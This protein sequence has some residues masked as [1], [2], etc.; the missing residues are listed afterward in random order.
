MTTLTIPKTLKEKGLLIPDCASSLYQSYRFINAE[1]EITNFI[2]E[3]NLWGF[4]L[5]APW[6]IKRVFGDDIVL[7]L[8]LHR[9]PTEDFEC[10][11]VT[12]RTSLPPES[13]VNLLAR[14]DEEWWL[15]VDD[16]IRNVLEIMVW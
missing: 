2:E 16:G 14:L 6:Q 9:D 11:F 7:E 3:N 10:L 12:I 8:Q 13:S 15:H 4:L 5:E 1:S